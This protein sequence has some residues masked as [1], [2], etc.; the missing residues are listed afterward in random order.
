MAG[1][2]F[3]PLF[4]LGMFVMIAAG[5]LIAFAAFFLL[6]LVNRRKLPATAKW[7]CRIALGGVLA[8]AVAWTIHVTTQGT[9]YG[10]T[11]YCFERIK[12]GMPIAEVRGIS[13]VFFKE[14]DVSLEEIESDPEHG[15]SRHPDDVPNDAIY[16]KK[17]AYRL[18]P[19]SYFYVTYYRNSD[20]VHGTIP[21]YE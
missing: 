18:W 16:A 13:G 19:G 5:V 8:A 15:F 7:I 9:V 21:V 12:Y 2:S 14:S 4:L 17:Y 20:R 11:N 10:H 3:L 1:N 6:R